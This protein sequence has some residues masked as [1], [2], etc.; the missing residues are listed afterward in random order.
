M[1]YKSVT[2][3]HFPSYLTPFE[4][5]HNTGPLTEEG[6]SRAFANDAEIIYNDL[7]KNIWETKNYYHFRNY[8]KRYIHVHIHIHM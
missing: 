8:T 4:K 2:D 3:E 5:Q 6:I 1:A 7:P